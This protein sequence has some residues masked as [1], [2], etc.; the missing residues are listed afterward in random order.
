MHEKRCFYQQ[1]KQDGLNISSL[2]KNCESQLPPVSDE[3]LASARDAF[4]RLI[5]EMDEFEHTHPRQKDEMRHRQFLSLAD[6]AC[7]MAEIYGLDLCF[8]IENDMTG[9]LTL[10]GDCLLMRREYAFD[11]LPMM[12]KL[13][14]LCEEFYVSPV[15]KD[16]EALMCMSFIVPL[17]TRAAV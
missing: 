12:Q 1:K 9:H 3:E 11:F 7:E 5:Q 4:S 15:E 6:A 14:E 16:G 17:Y 10:T 13:F 8:K 2:L